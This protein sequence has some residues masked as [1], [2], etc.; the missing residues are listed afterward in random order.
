MQ[1]AGTTG[2]RAD[3][4][5]EAYALTRAFAI[6]FELTNLAETAH[7]RRRRRAARLRTEEAPQPG[8][9]PR[10]AAAAARRRARQRR[11]SSRALADVEVVPVF[12]AH[13]TEVS[14][15]TVLFKR[16]RIAARAGA[17]STGCR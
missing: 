5:E 17:R 1:E 14:R 4:C 9:L 2:G 16:R 11:R 12:T 7:R 3:R 8:T 6:Y 13:P 10:H 15:R